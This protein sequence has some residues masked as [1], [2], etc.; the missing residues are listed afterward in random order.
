VVVVVVVVVEAGFFVF[1]F[2]SG[3]GFVPTRTTFGSAR[4]DEYQ[5]SS[6]RR[7]PALS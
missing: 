6:W 2:G 5:V 7:R 4:Y 1:F 3:F